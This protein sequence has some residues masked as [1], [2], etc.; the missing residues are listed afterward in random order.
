MFESGLKE[1]DLDNLRTEISA[2]LD[3]RRVLNPE[4]RIV[5]LLYCCWQD[6]QE[7]GVGMAR[8]ATMAMG[9]WAR[10]T[11]TRPEQGNG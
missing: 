3:E 9:A 11:E 5:C 7:R 1:N 8:V 10:F 6:A 2:K 4:H